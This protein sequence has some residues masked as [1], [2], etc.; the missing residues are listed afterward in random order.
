[1]AVNALVGVVGDSDSTSTATIGPGADG[2]AHMLSDTATGATV[3]FEKDG[4][5]AVLGPDST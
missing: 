3:W 2:I 5:I 4:N 1:V